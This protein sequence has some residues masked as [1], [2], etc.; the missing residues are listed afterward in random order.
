MQNLFMNEIHDEVEHFFF[1][2]SIKS[3]AWKLGVINVYF[4]RSF[5][6]SFIDIDFSEKVGNDVG[7]LNKTDEDFLYGN[8]D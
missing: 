6:R 7:S 1:V 5:I 4:G 3:N 2:H 8:R